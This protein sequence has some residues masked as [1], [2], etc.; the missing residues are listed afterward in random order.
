MFL[1]FGWGR[2]CCL[3]KRERLVLQRS[4]RF[5]GA[6]PTGNR[7]LAKPLHGTERDGDTALI[8]P[9]GDGAVSPVLAAQGEDGFTVR[10]EPAARPA[11]LSVSAADC[12]FM[13][14]GRPD[15]SVGRSREFCANSRLG[16]RPLSC[17]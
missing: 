7:P 5:A 2:C 15:N 12:R 4:R 9:L 16:A 17:A 11:L 1:R 10:F 6:W 3:R 14:I 8:E 13:G